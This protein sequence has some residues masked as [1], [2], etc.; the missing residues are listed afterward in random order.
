MSQKKVII[1]GGGIAGLTSAIYL[2]QAGANVTVLEKAHTIGG[3][4]T[5]QIRDGFTFNQG[6]HALYLGGEGM[7]VLTEL[8]IEPHGGVPGL[9]G[10]FYHGGRVLGLPGSLKQFGPK[11]IA[12]LPKLRHGPQTPHQSLDAWLHTATTDPKAAQLVR[13]ISRLSTYT[14]APALQS[15][16]SFLAQLRI[17]VRGNVLYIKGGWGWLVDSLA[18]KATSAGASIRTRVAAERVEHGGVYLA[19]G[20][21][22]EADDVII[23]ASP[24]IASELVPNSAEL[25]R[26]SC[27]VVPIRVATLDL[28]LSHLPR[29]RATFALGIDNP[30]YFSVHSAA[31]PEL[32]ASGGAMLHAMYSFGPNEEPDPAANRAEIESMIDLVQ[33]GWRDAVIHTRY[34]P[35]MTVSHAVIESFDARPVPNV[36]DVE[37]VW[38]AGDWVGPVGQLVDASFASAQAA[39]QG[40][41]NA[42]PKRNMERLAV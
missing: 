21:F 24:R 30:L 39:A 42:T 16:A 20:S 34:L 37:G 15:A 14:H 27:E 1:I 12:S 3:R 23:A 7:A 18:E 10:M 11:L 32:A 6:P 29:P 40:I 31:T 33:P 17:L 22:I 9:K 8:G 19:D 28:A 38:I 4:A 5:S 13:A 35:Q 26:I 41:L 2:A 36:P 25:Q